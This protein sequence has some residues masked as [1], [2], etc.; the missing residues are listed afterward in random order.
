MDV[1][2]KKDFSDT[3]FIGNEKVFNSLLAINSQTFSKKENKNGT[4]NYVMSK[5][6]VDTTKYLCTVILLVSG[7]I[8]INPGPTKKCNVCEKQL[9]KNSKF[10]L[11]YT[12][13]SPRD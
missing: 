12:S 2:L 10:C 4:V 13:P 3:Q 11:L 9:R 6:K 7:D 5:N 8:Q 1:H